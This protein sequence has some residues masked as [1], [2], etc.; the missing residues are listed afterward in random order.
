MPPPL[1]MNLYPY[2]GWV[3]I[4]VVCT[5]GC[6]HILL[7]VF[8]PFKSTRFTTVFFRGFDDLC[9]YILRINNTTRLVKTF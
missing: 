1:S 4:Y 7:D 3:I 6:R 9:T 5:S 8:F 2:K